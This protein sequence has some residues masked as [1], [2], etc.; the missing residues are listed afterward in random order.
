MIGPDRFDSEAT[1][2]FFIA[3]GPLPWAVAPVPSGC[4]RATGYRFN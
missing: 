4:A 3:A 1:S 2:E